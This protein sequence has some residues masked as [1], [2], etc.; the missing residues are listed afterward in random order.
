[1]NAATAL[2]M[3]IAV[4]SQ[5]YQPFDKIGGLGGNRHGIPAQLIRWRSDRG[6]VAVDEAAVD[7][8]KRAVNCGRSNAVEPR[9]SIG[10]ARGGER[11]GRKLLGIEPIGAALGRILLRQGARQRLAREMAGGAG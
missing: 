5:G 7:G 2:R 4:S 1:M 9:A 11:G 3:R 10:G 8:T 6:E